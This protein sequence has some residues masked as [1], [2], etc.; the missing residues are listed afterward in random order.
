MRIRDPINM[1]LSRALEAG[2]ANSDAIRQRVADAVVR[3]TAEPSLTLRVLPA[4]CRNLARSAPSEPVRATQLEAIN[5]ALFDWLAED[6]TVIVIGE[7][8]ARHMAAH[9]K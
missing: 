8:I 1:L 2:A 7:D 4:R 5:R 9:S 3:L 6:P